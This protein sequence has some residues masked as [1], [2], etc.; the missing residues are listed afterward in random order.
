MINR[1]SYEDESHWRW[2]LED[3][4]ALGLDG[5]ASFTE[6]AAFLWGPETER[7]RLLTYRLCGLTYNVDPRITLAVIEALERT[8]RIFFDHATRVAAELRE[9]EG[10][11]LRYFGHVHLGEELGHVANEEGLSHKLAKLEIDDALRQKALAAVDT[12]YDALSEFLT[13]AY[14]YARAQRAL[15][16]SETKGRQATAAE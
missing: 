16:H 13:E 9:E 2:L 7:S 15:P 1:H 12:A 10:V 4:K 8:G 5:N 14:A 11:D 6:H 3:M